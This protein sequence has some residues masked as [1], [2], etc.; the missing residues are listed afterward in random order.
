MTVF[1]KSSGRICVPQMPGG[2]PFD[3]FNDWL[4]S[5][6]Y[7][8]FDGTV[9]VPLLSEQWH[10][11]GLIPRL[12][13]DTG[14]NASPEQGVNA[15]SSLYNGFPWYQV[16]SG[17]CF[18]SV[19]Q[20][21][22]VFLPECSAPREPVV[23]RVE[24]AADRKIPVGDVFYTGLPA[25]S[26]SSSQASEPTSLNISGVGKFLE[27]EEQDKYSACWSWPRYYNKNGLSAPFTGIDTTD[28]CPFSTVGNPQW[29]SETQL[30]TR[31]PKTDSSGNVTFT[32][33]KS[34]KGTKA[35]T[36]S[37]SKGVFVLTDSAYPGCSWDG[38]ST[39]S[40]GSDA[41]F[42]LATHPDDVNPP[43]T[44]RLYAKKEGSL[45]VGGSVSVLIGEIAPWR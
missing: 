29:T 22:Y 30:F 12:S 9:L 26:Y 39:M 18:Y 37:S 45:S 21:T 14:S 2:S 17:C 6:D 35:V 4:V 19:G 1:F 41:S 33:R 10:D 34:G 13:I 44:V 20:G 7:I 25:F 43:S 42:A 3:V 32:F 28:S 38:L 31:V 11:C 8:L 40:A 23:A 36:W 27:E 24:A 5:R 15:Q 16:G